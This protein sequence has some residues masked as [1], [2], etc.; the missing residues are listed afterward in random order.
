LCGSREKFPVSIDKYRNSTSGKVVSSRV[1]TDPGKP[2]K[3]WN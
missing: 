3:S 1:A 2:G